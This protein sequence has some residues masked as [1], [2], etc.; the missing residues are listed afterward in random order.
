MNPKPDTKSE[1]MITRSV[2]AQVPPHDAEA[3]IAVVAALLSHA[4]A[5]ANV[6]GWLRG[7][8]FHSAALGTIYD[9]CVAV[10]GLAG[11]ID[12]VTV[13]SYLRDR[14]T[15][16]TVGGEAYL[17]KIV[18]TPVVGEN[19]IEH[20]LIVA[21]KAKARSLI[22]RHQKA[23]DEGY[24]VVDVN[25]WCDAALSDIGKLAADGAE[26]V[27]A[28][29]STAVQEMMS[30]LR[31]RD[32]SPAIGTGNATIDRTIGKLRQGHLIVAASY[33]GCGKSAWACNVVSHVLL[34]EKADGKPSGVLM[35]S[36]EMKRHE[37]TMRLAC[38]RARI[39]ST[40]IERDADGTGNDPPLT[41]NDPPLTEDETRRF[42]YAANEFSIPRLR[43]VDDS[44][45]TMEQIRSQAR[46]VAAEFRRA[47]TPLRLIVLDY[48]QIVSAGS[49]KRS[50]SREEEVAAIGR[51]AKKMAA[52]L[53][54]PVILLSQLNADGVKD[55]RPPTVGDMRESKALLNDANVAF[56]I[57]NPGV[58]ARAES[59]ERVYSPDAADNV[60]FKIGKRRSGPPCTVRALYWPVYCLFGD[61][62]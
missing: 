16:A 39:D 40:R 11:R 43:I 23:A 6:G 8:H 53:N 36:L 45:V 33:T 42:N 48:A 31:N 51:G 38:S 62:S 19:V 61:V 37:I 47:G 60:E 35:F 2:L 54:V 29:G 3:E 59:G 24:S 55:K 57:H 52:E 34:E 25:D 58:A 7:S 9:A 20:A 17:A 22:A 14:G 28:T 1:S 21:K 13:G 44:D 50:G 4:D 56:V 26:E 49:S 18:A 30:M 41:G 12:S 46:R 10:G 32:K 15:F 5:Y 27:G